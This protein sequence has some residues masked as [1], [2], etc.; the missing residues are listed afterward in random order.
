MMNNRCVL[1]LVAS[2]LATILNMGCSDSSAP[3]EAD[4]VEGSAEVILPNPQVTLFA[5]TEGAVLSDAFLV[6]TGALEGVTSG[7]VV[8]NGVEA[9]LDPPVFSAAIVLAEGEN[10]IVAVHE[11]SGVSDTVTV[12]LDSLPP[13]LLIVSPGHGAVYPQ[14]QSIDVSFQTSDE[15]GVAFAILDGKNCSITDGAGSATHVGKNTGLDLVSLI[16]V[17][18]NAIAAREHTAA[19]FGPFEECERDP[20][21]PDLAIDLGPEGLAAM[22]TVFSTIVTDY[23]WGA[24]LAE[25]NP[26]YQSDQ[27]AMSLDN[28]E[29]VNPQLDLTSE[30]AKDT[31]RIHMTLTMDEIAAQ[32]TVT[33]T[34]LDMTWFVDVQVK[35]LETQAVT[36]LDFDQED[37]SISLES[38]DAKADSFKVAVVD[39]EGK[40]VVAPVE[41]TGNVL[42]SIAQIAADIVVEEA[43]EKLAAAEEY[44][45]GQWPFAFAGL[46]LLISYELVDIFLVGGGMRGLFNV[47]VLWPEAAQVVHPWSW[48]CPDLSSG[49]PPADYLTPLSLGLSVDFLNR[50]LIGLWQHG[51]FDFTV[52]QEALDG[53]KIEM[54]LVA[55][56][57]GSLLQF[58]PTTVSPEAPI[59]VEIGPLLPPLISPAV[60]DEAGTTAFTLGLGAFR[61]D[62][63]DQSSS[64]KQIARVVFSAIL[65]LD[66]NLGT[67]SIDLKL[68][69]DVFF[70]DLQGLEG[71]GKRRAEADIE[72][73]F[74]VLVPEVVGGVFQLLA[75]FDMPGVFGLEFE[76]ATV[77]SD[78]E[79]GYLRIRLDALAIAGG[80]P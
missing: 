23:D 72:Q 7:P 60:V 64:L 38:L 19:L 52:D 79:N 22:G 41:V 77:D 44:A 20:T 32:G 16:A 63:V 46:D 80:A 42:D 24:V 45:E 73:H 30:G 65:E 10:E 25:K 39:D 70:L 9:Q 15:S 43:N 50:T 68:E 47:D 37:V 31:G 57:L 11:P 4:L 2:L 35:G 55:G 26:V 67:G 76:E 36:R 27:L 74:E 48:G 1:L 59:S 5:P 29:V 3:D 75:S 34:G 28:L 21:V 62:F 61:L 49:P 40:E 14:P 12:L 78:L 58:L 66:A 51:L 13:A 6:V 71:D 56:L 54:D 18:T 33:F 17:D 53:W 69:P 8:V